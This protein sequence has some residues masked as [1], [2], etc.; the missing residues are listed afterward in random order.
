MQLIKQAPWYNPF[1][2]GE[3]QIADIKVF[4]SEGVLTSTG[5]GWFGC[6]NNPINSLEL[7]EKV[8]RCINPRFSS[9]TPFYIPVTK[10]NKGQKQKSADLYLPWEFF[11]WA[12]PYEEEDV[13]GAEK[14]VYRIYPARKPVEVKFRELLRKETDKD[15]AGFC[16]RLKKI[17]ELSGGEFNQFT[18]LRNRTEIEELIR[19]F[20]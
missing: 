13:V 14:Y 11:T 16:D 17:V 20:L 19:L 5:C 15:K 7:G 18:A 2:L 12:T 6:G 1:F 3:Y 9:K 4:S 8:E 10:L